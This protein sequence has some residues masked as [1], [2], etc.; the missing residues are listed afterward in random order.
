MKM[1]LKLPR[2]FDDLGQ[3]FDGVVAVIDGP[4]V[5]EFNQEFLRLFD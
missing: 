5:Q 1:K 3:D 4:L 2:F